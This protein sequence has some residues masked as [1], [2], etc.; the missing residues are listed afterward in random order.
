[1]LTIALG[2]ASIDCRWDLVSFW[3]GIVKLGY[4]TVALLTAVPALLTRAGVVLFSAGFGSSLVAVTVLSLGFCY[5]RSGGD[6]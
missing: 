3:I 2:C 5:I 6:I 1:M 4:A